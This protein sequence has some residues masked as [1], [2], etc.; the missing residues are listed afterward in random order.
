MHG[1]YAYRV[2]EADLSA[3]GRHYFMRRV[4]QRPMR[5][6]LIAVLVL[7]MLLVVLDFLDDGALKLST[8]IVL[9]LAIPLIWL[10]P[11][12]IA[13]AIMRRQYRQ[14]ASLRDENRVEFD[15][16][17]I[18]FSN[19]RGHAR[20]P[21]T[22]LYAWSETDRMVLLHQTEAFFNPIPKTALGP[23]CHLLIAALE[24]AGVRRF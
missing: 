12:L 17:A 14:S 22:E 9:V 24:E 20:I 16:E 11:Y 7:A 1:P 2:E 13:P 8:I 15:R 21:L 18:R 5:Y 10:V 3:A 19:T 4:F 6:L 23:D